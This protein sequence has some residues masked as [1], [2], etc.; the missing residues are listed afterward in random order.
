MRFP[1]MNLNNSR[2]EPQPREGGAPN[3]R[4]AR[5]S[6]MSLRKDPKDAQPRDG[7]G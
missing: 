3:Q 4:S 5:P 6:S 2:S 1:S 7:G